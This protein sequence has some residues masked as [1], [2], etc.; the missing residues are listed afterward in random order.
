MP[1]S[2]SSVGRRKVTA[3]PRPLPQAG[4]GSDLPNWSILVLR[5]PGLDPGSIAAPSLW[6][7][8]QVRDDDERWSGT[9]LPP[10]GGAARLASLLASRS[11]VGHRI[12]AAHPQPLPQAGGEINVRNWRFLPFRPDVRH[13]GL[14]PGSTAALEQRKPDQVGAWPF[15]TSIPFPGEGRGP[16]GAALSLLWPGFRRG[17]PACA[18]RE[19]RKSHSPVRR[20]CRRRRSRCGCP[21]RQAACPVAAYARRRTTA[22][23][24]TGAGTDS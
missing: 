3:H 5:H 10:A 18:I 14:D 11:G 19:W 9:P 16:C 12:V 21:S 22:P 23:G 20:A 2:R 13:T 6:T 1:A 7:P 17:T 15:A 24:G 4:G 8:Y